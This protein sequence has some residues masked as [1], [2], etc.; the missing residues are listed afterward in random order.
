MQERRVHARLCQACTQC[1]KRPHLFLGLGGRV[2]GGGRQMCHQA[3][4]F[5]VL[6]GADCFQD[7]RC[8]SAR[9]QPSHPAVDLQMVRNRDALLGR[10]P[11]PFGDV[12][13]CVNYGREVIVEQPGPFVRQEIRHH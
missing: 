13:E 10:Q 8:R 4:Q 6:C 12:W 11:V 7:F 2:I 3:L 1:F 9:A 5:R